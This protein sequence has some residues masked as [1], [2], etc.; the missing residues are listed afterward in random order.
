M[1]GFYKALEAGTADGYLATADMWWRP[2]VE[3]PQR[4]S[5]VT[6]GVTGGAKQGDVATWRDLY[7]RHPTFK[8]LQQACPQGGEEHEIR[9]P[10][11]PVWSEDP[12][13]VPPVPLEL[14]S[15]GLA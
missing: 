2:V 11:F 10:S 13:P 1:V 14:I 7:E 5:P 4:I 12:T 9:N 15:E 6:G 3:Y 8:R